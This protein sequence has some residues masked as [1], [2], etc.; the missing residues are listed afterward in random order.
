MGINID[1][2]YRT[3]LEVQQIFEKQFIFS[4]NDVMI[5]WILFV[6]LF[7][8][9]MYIFPM[10]KI[11]MDMNKKLKEQQVKKLALKQ[12]LIQKEI[13]NEIQKEIENESISSIS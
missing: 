4:W 12:I 11:Y 2:K 5:F 8:W 1:Y 9:I 13:E 10:M 6:L 3:Y 7:I